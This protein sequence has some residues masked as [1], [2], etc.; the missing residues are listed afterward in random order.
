MDR[1]TQPLFLHLHGF[2]P[3]LLDTCVADHGVVRHMQIG[4]GRLD[5]ELGHLPLATGTLHTCQHTVGMRVQGKFPSGH[6]F[7]LV[8][9]EVPSR[10][11]IVGREVMRDSVVTF[12]PGSIVDNLYGP[13]MC[14]AGLSVPVEVFALAVRSG[15]MLEAF[16]AGTTIIQQPKQ[17]AIAALRAVLASVTDFAHRQPERFDDARWRSDAEGNLLDA[18]LAAFDSP[19]DEQRGA[20]VTIPTRADTIVRTLDGYLDTVNSMVPVDELCR[21]A[22]L[23]RRTLERAYQQTLDLGPAE[24][25]RR[26]ALNAVRRELLHGARPAGSVTETAMR[27]GF[28]H[29]G[30]FAGY[31]RTLFGESPSETLH[32]HT[33]SVLHRASM[34]AQSALRQ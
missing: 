24:Y 34:I 1:P 22:Q 18:Y 25:V 6:I 10:S 29:L 21:V 16:E 12:G 23:P 9:L 3:D 27:H 4:P 30:R 13:G 19:I 20:H 14:W 7:L 17:A 8:C 28:W 32:R 26:R 5:G 11:R 33:P 15:S 2:D 31:Y